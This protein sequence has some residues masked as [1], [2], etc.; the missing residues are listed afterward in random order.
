MDQLDRAYGFVG[1][2]LRGGVRGGV[3]SQDAPFLTVFV[4][5]IAD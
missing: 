4:H 2:F 3:Y 1:G 5:R